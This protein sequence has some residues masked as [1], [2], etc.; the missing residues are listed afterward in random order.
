[1]LVRHHAIGTVM[2]GLTLNTVPQ[3]LCRV[4]TF[5]SPA[6]RR[7]RAKK[8]TGSS[9]KYNND[10]AASATYDLVPHRYDDMDSA[11]L[12]TLSGMGIHSARI[13]ILIRHI[14]AV[15]CCSRDEATKVSELRVDRVASY[16]R[17]LSKAA[18]ID[19]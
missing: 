2:R 5:S 14:M 16:Q 13:E 8:N 6:V 1:M 12:L 11:T 17:I 4:R 10:R 7:F 3:T 9:I 18:L 19:I 15:D